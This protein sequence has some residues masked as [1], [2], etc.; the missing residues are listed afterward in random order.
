[1]LFNPLKL[2]LSGDIGN[3][4]DHGFILTEGF[5]FGFFRAPLSVI[6]VCK[7]NGFVFLRQCIVTNFHPR[8]CIVDWRVGPLH[9]VFSST[10]QWA[11]I[12]FRGL[13][14]GLWLPDMLPHTPW[15][16]HNSNLMNPG[17]VI[18]EYRMHLPSGKN[19]SY[20]GK[21]GLFSKSSQLSDLMCT[22]DCW[23]CVGSRVL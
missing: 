8:S 10:S 12:K 23:T 5:W 15:I 14:S 13:R 22:Y 21:I 2:Y 1:M 9:K 17:I 11:V 6:M 20:D 3:P 4:F 18:L 16:N 7:W 19:Y